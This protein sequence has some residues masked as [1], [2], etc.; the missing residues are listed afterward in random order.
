MNSLLADNIVWD[1]D[2]SGT[3][4]SVVSTNG[5]EPQNLI[6]PSSSSFSIRVNVYWSLVTTQKTAGVYNFEE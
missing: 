4:T 1:D 6:L 5:M 3:S 2:L